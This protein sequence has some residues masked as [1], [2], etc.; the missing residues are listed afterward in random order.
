METDD[1]IQ[2]TI[3]E[4]LKDV[5]VLTIVSLSLPPPLLRSS[6]AEFQHPSLSLFSFRLIV[7]ARSS[8]TIDFS[9]WNKVG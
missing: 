6:L 2:K 7:S 4:E 9:F 1:L 8:I 3:R 5:T